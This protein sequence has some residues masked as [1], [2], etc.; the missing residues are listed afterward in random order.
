M[1]DPPNGSWLGSPVDSL[2]KDTYYY[3]ENKRLSMKIII[4]MDN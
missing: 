1:T 2:E 4:V 3:P